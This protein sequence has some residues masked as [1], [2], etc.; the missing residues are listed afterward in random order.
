M[1]SATKEFMVALQQIETETPKPKDHATGKKLY[2]LAGIFFVAAVVMS[3]D[4]AVRSTQC[5]ECKTI[6]SILFFSI[7][8]ILMII[9][10]ELR[11]KSFK[12]FSCISED[13]KKLERMLMNDGLNLK[14]SHVKIKQDI[15]LQRDAWREKMNALFH[16][17][18]KG[19]SLFVLTPMGFM[20]TL[21]LSTAYK[22]MVF[23]STDVLS[24][25]TLAIL[26]LGGT[27]LLIVLTALL[28]YAAISYFA[29]PAYEEKQ[30]GSYLSFLEDVE[31]YYGKANVCESKQGDDNAEKV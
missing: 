11:Q 14:E 8:V 29:I 21:L 20:F 22:D 1:M 7:T 6:L 2:A 18:T 5:K 19:V 9:E 16:T 31:V 17:A 26:S 12:P 25:E 27:L 4:I 23:N 30:Y 15:K 3:T 28:F 13:V 24:A 10:H